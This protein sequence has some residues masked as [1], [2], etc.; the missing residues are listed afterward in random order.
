VKALGLLLDGAR[1]HL[2]RGYDSGSTRERL[3]KLGLVGMTSERGKPAPLAS[4]RRWVV[5][6]LNSWQNAHKKL[7]WCTERHERVIDFWVSFSNVV[8]IVGRLIREGW[9]RYRWERR[10]RRRP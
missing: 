2:D 10:S 3:Q 5:E 4:T 6:R 1:V 7:A 8:I 9:S